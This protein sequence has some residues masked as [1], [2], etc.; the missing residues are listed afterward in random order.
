MRTALKLIVVLAAIIFIIVMGSASETV[1][2]MHAT[3]NSSRAV[4]YGLHVALPNNMKNFPV[5]SAIALIAQPWRHG[6]E[7]IGSGATGSPTP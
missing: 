3:K 7:V 1:T 6:I 4:V 5:A 2:E